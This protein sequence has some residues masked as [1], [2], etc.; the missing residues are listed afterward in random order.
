[1]L[2]RR[3]LDLIQFWLTGVEL[4]AFKLC[5]GVSLQSRYGH[6]WL[7]DLSEC[8]E[9]RWLKFREWNESLR[10]GCNLQ[11]NV[12][13]LIVITQFGHYDKLPPVVLFLGAWRQLGCPISGWLPGST[14]LSAPSAPQSYSIIHHWR[15][16]LKIQAYAVKDLLFFY[17]KG[18][19]CLTI[20]KVL[21]IY[22]RQQCV[23]MIPHQCLPYSS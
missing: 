16:C 22:Y 19:S 17:Q 1:M 8:Y 23:D 18:W 15:I 2:Y 3:Q 13:T 14:L 10:W 5:V 20:I 9:T 12:T 11:E 6:L 4:R 21:W 7:V